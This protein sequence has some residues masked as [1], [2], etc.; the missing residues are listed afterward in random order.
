VFPSTATDPAKPLEADIVKNGHIHNIWTLDLTTNEL[1]QYTDALGATLSPAVLRHRDIMRIAFVTYYKGEWSARAID[2]K[3][4]IHSAASSD[5]GSPG[6][7]V[8]FQSPLSH[9]LVKANIRPKKMFEKM[10]IQGVPAVSVAVSNSGDVFGGTAIGFGDV[11]GDQQFLVYADSSAQYTSSSRTLLFNWSNRSR[12]FQYAL[13]ARA[14]TNFFYATNGG[15]FYDP[16]FAPLLTRQDQLA[17][18][19]ERGG[20]IFGIYPFDRYRRVEMFGGFFNVRTEFAEAALEQI[21]EQTGRPADEVFRN[22]FAVPLG[23]TFVQET[24]VFREFGPLSGN[25]VRFGYIYEPP[26]SELQSSTFDLDARYYQRLATSGVLALR[27]RGFKSV[28]QNR[29][30]LYF[31]GN[32]E[33]RGYEYL[34]FLGNNAVFANAE[35]RFPIIDAANTPIGVVGA[36]RGVFFVNV[37]AGWFNGEPFKFFATESER[38]SPLLS[39]SFNPVTGEPIPVY[40]PERT[41]DGFRLR[42]ARGSYGFGLETFLLGFPLHFDWSWRTLF[43]DDWE[44]AL[45]ATAG[46]SD[47]FRKPQFAI[48]VGYDF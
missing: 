18:H 20:S 16:V 43:N 29:R 22:G 2:L 4:P 32:S 45:F 34:E 25:T 40:G 3:D 38:Y 19:S 5:F 47:E 48:W 11:L 39:V 8:D 10:F 13:E 33:M 42:D 1:R 7:I 21:L 24:T 6:P 17:T 27:F 35:L 37:G 28:G 23:M 46:G 15:V 31:G 36:L 14:Q 9:T 26:F 12:R 41:I 44:D 30:Q